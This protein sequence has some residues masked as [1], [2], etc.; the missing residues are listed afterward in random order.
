MISKEKQDLYKTEN[1]TELSLFAK[2]FIPSSIKR[3]VKSEPIPVSNF[4]FQYSNNKDTDKLNC[5]SSNE[6]TE[7]TEQTETDHNTSELKTECSENIILSANSYGFKGR[8]PYAT[9]MNVN[10]LNISCFNNNSNSSS[11]TSIPKIDSNQKIINGFILTELKDK[12]FDYRCTVCDFVAHDNTELRKHLVAKKH[13]IFPKK[14]KKNK[15]QKMYHKPDTRLNQTFFCSSNKSNKFFEKKLMCQHCSKK[16]ESIYALNSH[17]NAHKFKCDIC[18]KL[19]N[20]KEEL[21]EHKH[22]EDD[23]KE[24]DSNY[25]NSPMKKKINKYKKDFGVKK[26]KIEID[27]WEEV[28]SNKKEKKKDK[29]NNSELEESYVFMEENDENFDFNRMIKINDGI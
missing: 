5:P 18:F 10:S 28:S 15:K 9:S 22:N 14:N 1:T 7:Q 16:F 26:D 24:R 11:T 13:F 21:M 27:D 20:H 6:K 25:I 2:E 23:V 29:K 17:L 4:S 12:V 3:R 8:S 19:F